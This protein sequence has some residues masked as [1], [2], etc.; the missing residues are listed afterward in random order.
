M[1]RL[2]VASV[3]V[4]AL[5]AGGCGSPRPVA[6]G[7]GSA[8][9]GAAAAAGGGA[10]EDAAA[11][12]LAALP[13]ARPDPAAPPDARPDLPPWRW[14]PVQK[15]QCAG[16]G[17]RQISA[18]LRNVPAGFSPQAA[19][20]NA[21]RNVMGIDFDRPDRCVDGGMTGLRGQWDVPD[22]SCAATAPGPPTRGSEGELT[23]AA[24][25]EG[26]ADLHLHQMAHLGFGGSVVWGAAFG[27]P[28]EALLPIPAAMKRGHD[29]SEALF[30]GDLAGALTGLTTHDESGYPAFTSW[31]SRQLATH[32]QAY[33]DWLFRAY[34]GG[35]R[36]MVMLAVNSEDMFAR[37]ENDL[38]ALGS[39][40]AQPVRAP[41]RSTNDMETLEW[42]V[43]EAY[44]MQEHVDALDGGP[45]RGWYRIVRDPAEAGA[46]IAQG[47][48]AVVL[49]T[50]LQHLFNCDADRPACTSDTII[51]GLDR[52]EAMGVNYVFPV[53]HK[54]NQFGG[55][56]QF[57]PLTNGPTA[58]CWETQER[59]SAAGLS[60]LGR[61]LV[62]ELT[63]RGMLVDT[64]HLSWKSFDDAMAIAEAR[65]YPVLASHIGPFDLKA[66][67]FQT[68]QVRRTDQIRRILD[69]G[70][71][72]GVILG[73]GVEEYARSKGAPVTLPIS[74]GGGDRWANAYLYVR[75][76]AR[77]GLGP[78]GAGRISFGS[79]WNG[80]ASWPGPRYGAT[81]CAA[82]TARDGKPIPKP[83]PVVYP[84]ALP[85]GLVPAAVGGTP[86][87]PRFDQFHPWDYNA[88]GLM[89]AGLIP[90][91]LEDLRMMGL[92]LADLEPLYRSARG[93]VELWRTAR[94]R[95][96]PGDR[97][98][99]RWIPRSA[100]DLL[101]FD[102]SDPTRNI[103][104]APGFPLC[105]RRRIHLLGF[106]QNGAC[107]L[108]EPADPPVLSGTLA[109]VAISA[110]HA[111]RC[112]D[113]DRASAAD[114]ARVH[115]WTCNAGDSQR[116]KLRGAEGAWELINAG[117]GKCLDGEAMVSGLLGPSVSQRACAGTPGQRWQAVRTGNTFSL[118][119]DSGLC[120]EVASQS[121]ADGAAV[122]PAPCTGAAHQQW[123]IESLRAADHERLYQADRNRIAWL[124]APDAAHPIPVTV[125]G[126][127]AVCRG[128][129]WLGVVSGDQCI[130]RTYA[131]APASSATFDRL[132]QAH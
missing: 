90:D 31:P 54:L 38:G 82:R 75:D 36:L 81:P 11:A 107:Q 34:Q 20:Q 55:P 45:G 92:T 27:P 102:A 93:L 28:A 16:E 10:A 74:C 33:E 60:P 117:S 66:D 25:L 130:G 69:V 118:R 17:L 101:A 73:V 71:M 105:R 94:D 128:P 58:E 1:S 8:V 9:D 23:S 63:A 86:T 91:F 41:A 125:D 53:H 21:P 99:V 18:P 22:S 61:F 7:G 98:Q 72:L 116:W 88:L 50:E 65:S 42:Q 129:G 96:V 49:G 64:E 46:A 124:S 122:A 62:E 106:E 76:L 132:L 30:D 70:G 57:N 4:L 114:G 103:E 56:S 12:D 100:F 39:I 24:P 43:R 84:L 35:L 131:G 119:S 48:M 67:A 104:A 111:G 109:P 97:H 15:N 85:D 83:G 120:L 3:S 19:C 79:D 47:K 5:V 108:V 52:L 68:E 26:Y 113:V 40:P 44:R 112:L 127:R 37:G 95:E 77:G 29:R 123:D 80:F 115:Q 110:Y 126:T 51:E 32:Q 6:R 89:H 87:L 2:P 121:R 59:C 78:D 14:G 13:D